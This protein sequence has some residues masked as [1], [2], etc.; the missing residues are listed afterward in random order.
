MWRR[1]IALVALA[2][3]LLGGPPFATAQDA[4]GPINCAA[5]GEAL[6]GPR[7]LSL[8]EGRLVV[9]PFLGRGG[10]TDGA[11]TMRLAYYVGS[12]PVVFPT[13]WSL[14]PMQA[15]GVTAGPRLGLSEASQWQ[16]AGAE[17]AFGDETVSVTSLG[18]SGALVRTVTVDLDKTPSLAVQTPPGSPAFDLKVNGGTQTVDTLLKPIERL[19]AATADVAAATGWHGVKTFQVRLYVFKSHPVAFTRIQFLG[20][21][22]P[23]AFSERNTWRPDEILSQTRLGDAAGPVQ[24]AV[25][26]P[27]GDGVSQRLL[28][29]PKGPTSLTLSGQFMGSIHWDEAQNT[30]LLQGD[31]YCAALC[32]SRHAKWLGVRAS[33]LDWAL[34]GGPTAGTSGTWRLAFSGLRPGDSIVIA[35]RFVPS[36]GGMSQAR[37]AAQAQA[38]DARFR[39]AVAKNE[40]DWNRRLALVPRPLDFTPRSVEAKGVPPADVRRAYYRAWVFLWQD[41]LPP[42]PEN[43]FSYPQVCTGKPSLWGDGAP[44]SE[45]TA[46][47]D[48]AEAMQALALVEPG[49]TWEAAQGLMSQ[50]EADGYLA[51]EAL[52]TVLAQTFWQVYEQTGDKDKLRENYPALKRYVTWKIAHPRWVY[53]NKSRADVKPS[54][55]KDNE[56]VVH[57]LLDMGYALKIAE[58]LG[59]P[60]E[61][62]FWRQ[63]RRQAA[64]NYLHWF[65]PPPGDVVYRVYASDTDPGTPDEVWGV[66]GLDLPPD[67]LPMPSRQTLLGVFR[68]RFSLARPFG[69]TQTRF[70]DLEPITLGLFQFGQI[71]LARQMA[72]LAQRDVTRA[73]E[74]SETYTQDD[75]PRPGG[76]RPSSFG[77]RLMTDSVFWHNGVVLDRGLPVL[78]GMPG[79]VGVDNVPVEGL[80]LNVHFDNAAH[81]VILSGAALSRLRLPPGFHQDKQSQWTGSIAEGQTVPLASAGQPLRTKKPS[82]RLPCTRN[83]ARFGYP[84]TITGSACTPSWGARA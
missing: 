32:V 83:R 74:F 1:V 63:Q 44:H 55:Q 9:N 10:L 68:R 33:P 15:A 36:P 79:A 25:T 84:K 62:A 64:D 53:P 3:V 75:P 59:L 24:S 27:S 37:E 60:G 54:T 72:D 71:G 31:G 35:A 80:P 43:G 70:G 19:G 16:T 11:L 28:I 23:S 82:E 13:F 14:L 69:I 73:G 66:K 18:S 20:L 6:S 45:S 4:A 52:P 26:L 12:S 77:A 29:G 76:V 46:A 22:A 21:P 57:E 41:T 78:L 67:L 30:L 38:S 48:G 51:G 61:A 65:L 2:C 42:M 7:W 39:A 47:W 40:A 34:G 81:A 8:P 56:Y 5:L 17:A 50:V 58:A 49:L